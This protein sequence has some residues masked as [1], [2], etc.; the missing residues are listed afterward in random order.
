MSKPRVVA[1][2]EARMGSS[3]LPGKVLADIL[4]KPALSRL[5]ARLQ[6]CRLLDA[7]VLATTT[8]AADQVL[9]DWA[10]N[11]QVSCF[12]GS[13]DDVLQRVVEAH[14]SMQSEIIVEITGDCILLDPEII[15]LAICTFLENNCDVVTNAR[16]PSFPL[17]ADVQVYRLDD[18]QKVART[19]HDPAVREHVSLY[20]YEHPE[21]YRV[22]HLLAP[23]RW[24]AP[25]LRLHLDYPED[26]AFINAVYSRLAPRFGDAFGIEEIMALLRREPQL[27]EINAHCVERAP[28]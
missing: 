27:A 10:R 8:S 9:A 22:I 12:R 20:F 19:V 21:R 23:A 28:R 24:V 3:R 16:K 13:E 5:L 2:I 6:R 26:L 18:L 25:T 17:G 15:D 14:E 4:G 1:S 11:A 7:I